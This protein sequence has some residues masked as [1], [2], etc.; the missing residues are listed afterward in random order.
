MEA[1]IDLVADR[2]DLRPGQAV[3]DIGCGYGATAERLAERHGLHVT[4]V[5]ISAVQAARGA[6]RAPTR[7]SL[8]V[9]HQD[10][11]VNGFTAESFDH[12]WAIE[13]SEHMAD[14]ARFFAEA[15]RTLKPGGR[16][17]VCAWLARPG[18]RAWEIRHLLEPICREGR[19]PGM[20]D[21]ADYRRLA[22]EAGF[23]VAAVEDLSARVRR[24]WW[25]CARRFA[26]KLA[27]DP[28]YAR[29]LLDQGSGNRVFA[30]TL[31]RLLVAYRTGSM[32]YGLMVLAKGAGRGVAGHA[33][34]GTARRFLG[35]ACGHP[36]SAP[37]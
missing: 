19:L 14:K 5:T 25:V 37:S 31:L 12:A 30:L 34:S 32:R 36:T 11:L 26:W 13:S 35:G 6:A 7:G 15:F 10:W 21:E 29:F 17:A 2:L 20:G 22:G 16:L 1:L 33:T 8:V 18:P 4:G 23:A 27:A 3:C 9:R 28:R 24:T